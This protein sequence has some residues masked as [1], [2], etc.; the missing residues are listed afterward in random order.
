MHQYF[1][2]TRKVTSK[3]NSKNSYGCTNT[4]FIKNGKG[5]KLKEILG[6]DGKVI[7]RTKK[8]LNR[9]EMNAIVKGEFVP[10]FWKGLC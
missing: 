1:S 9:K 5:Y 4:V 3:P 6:K 10:G 7:N 8:N 2:V